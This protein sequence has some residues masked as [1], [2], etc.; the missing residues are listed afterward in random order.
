MAAMEY[1]ENKGRLEKRKRWQHAIKYN[2]VF[3]YNMLLVSRQARKL[4][5]TQRR[6]ISFSRFFFSS[7]SSLILLQQFI[8]SRNDRNGREKESKIIL[9]A[10]FDDGC[11]SLSKKERNELKSL[12]IIFIYL[13]IEWKA[14][15]KSKCLYEDYTRH[16][17]FL[18]KV[19]DDMS[20]CV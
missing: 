6:I 8:T 15:K 18:Y 20:W 16:R 17:A 4:R 2:A 13:N 9:V 12:N 11:H 19:I 3:H 1:E 5:S 10:F 14:L 7:F